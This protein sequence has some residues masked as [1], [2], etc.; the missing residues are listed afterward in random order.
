MTVVIKMK[1]KLIIIGSSCLLLCVCLAAWL[2]KPITRITGAL[3]AQSQ[4][5][6]E[7]YTPKQ[8]EAI[9]S[10]LDTLIQ[11]NH[12]TQDHPLLLYN[13][14]GTNTL[15]MY[16]YFTTAKEAKL[17]Y[18]IH[19]EDSAI[20]DFH[21]SLSSAYETTFEY[22]LL[23]LIADEENTITLHL[24][25]KDG[26]TKDIVETFT[27]PSLS[28]T[29]DVQLTKTAGTSTEEVSDG[30]YVILGNDSS[31]AD[32]MYYYDNDGVLRGE[33][34]IKGYRSHRLLFANDRMYFSIS[35]TEI[36]EM[37]RLGQITHV[38]D[39]GKYKLHH[40]YV[41]DDDGN[42]LILTSDATKQTVEDMIIRLHTDTGAVDLVCDLGDLFPS[43]KA[44]ITAA[45]KDDDELDWM[46]INTI[47]WLGDEQIL[48]SSR[49]TSTMIKI[50]HLYS[51]PRI[52]YMIGEASYWKDTEYEDLLLTK[53]GSFTSQTGQHSITYVD[54]P[55]LPDGQY[56][57][58]LFNN[59]FGF[60][61]SNTT[62][63][64]SQL[65]VPTKVEDKNAHSL[66]YQYLVDEKAGTYTLTDSFQVPFSPYVSSVQNTA[67]T[68][69]VDSG[70]A[71]TFGE[72]DKD[73]KLIQSFQM[74]GEKYIYRVY[75]YTFDDFYFAQD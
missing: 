34:P 8:Q 23:G 61:S 20:A 7:I 70:M 46:H 22:Q 6:Q 15:S 49:E 63:D 11:T 56:Y 52:A 53:E 10:Q 60:S 69:I 68:T 37:D 19:V 29:E 18:T 14:F 24:E 50:D 73:H 26:T 25:Y 27:C 31:D 32:F 59:N 28:G 1:K 66:Y 75:K 4:S 12:Y 65:S 57:L 64:W 21:Q 13:P 71:F 51:S 33:V 41:F 55:S 47:Q 45:N 58:Y 36:A 72:Y 16:T 74:E 39:L 5:V 43:Y 40:D 3:S 48:I 35:E 38:Y 17:S 54:D 2:T 44:D 67:S 42:M 9:R 30:L 62:Y